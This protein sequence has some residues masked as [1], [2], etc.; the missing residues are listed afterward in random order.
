M[1]YLLVLPQGHHV[2]QGALS[3]LFLQEICF[4]YHLKILVLHLTSKWSY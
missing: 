1:E 3:L 2:S 4:L